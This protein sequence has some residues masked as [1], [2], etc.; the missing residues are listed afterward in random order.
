MGKKKIL[1]PL[2]I[3]STLLTTISVYTYQMLYSPNFLINSKDKLI[4]IEEGRNFNDLILKL[5]NDTIINDI[6]SFSFLS[7]LMEYQENIKE[8]AYKIKSNMSNYEAISMLRA[9]NQTPIN[10][11]FNYARKIDDLAEKITSKLKMNKDDLLSYLFNNLNDFEGFNESNIISIFL[12]DTYEVYWNISPK[13]LSE[14]M[15]SEYNTFWNKK[16]LDKLKKINLN[17]KE[18]AVL[19]SIVASETRMIDEADRIAGLYLNR[20]RRNM[21]LQADP[22]LIFSAND[23]TIRRVLNVHKKIKSP[24]NTY[25]NRGLPPGPIRT[26]SKDY[27]DAVL[28]YEEHN[29]IYMCAKEDFSGYHAFATNLSDHNRNARKFQIALDSRKIYR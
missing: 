25:I 9:G 6:L 22:T 20:L 29:Y 12:P 5:E 4:V 27:I 8:G 15:Y 2:I 16:R 21:R 14:K 28:N 24:Y 1:I 23:F 10:L 17:Q 7:K 26:T 13:K 19:A 3:F 11:T 18:V